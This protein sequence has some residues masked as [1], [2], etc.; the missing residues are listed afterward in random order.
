LQGRLDARHFR[1]EYTAF[2]GFSV[3]AFVVE[4]DELMAVNHRNPCFFRMGCVNQHSFGHFKSPT[5]LAASP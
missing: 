3:L 5:A 4:F 1:Q 2:E